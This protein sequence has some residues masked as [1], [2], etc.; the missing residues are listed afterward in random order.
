MTW[1][2]GIAGMIA[3]YMAT[4]LNERAARS[5]R[6]GGPVAVGA[7]LFVMFVIGLVTRVSAWQNWWNFAFACLFF[8]VGAMAVST[9]AVDHAGPTASVSEIGKREEQ[10]RFGKSA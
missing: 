10:N 6:F 4:H 3:F 9:R 7:A 1:L 2:D 5:M 8:L